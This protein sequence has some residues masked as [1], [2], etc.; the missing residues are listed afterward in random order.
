MDEAWYASQQASALSS[1]A[2]ADKRSAGSRRQQAARSSGV[3]FGQSRAKLL[4]EAERSSLKSANSPSASAVRIE[5]EVKTLGTVRLYYRQS[6]SGG[7]AVLGVRA[8]GK[9]PG[10]KASV[11]GVVSRVTRTGLSMTCGRS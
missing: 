9:P 8:G 6:R 4:G 11:D 2:A 1:F 3:S 5:D 7:S 10:L